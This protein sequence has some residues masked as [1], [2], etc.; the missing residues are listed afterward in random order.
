MKKCKFFFLIFLFFLITGC[1][2][3]YKIEIYKDKVMEETYAWYKNDE[4]GDY[5]PYGK[6]LEITRKYDANGDFLTHDSKKDVKKVGYTGVKLTR[7]Y[8]TID[9]FKTDSRILGSCYIATNLSNHTEYITLKTTQEFTC[10]DMVEEFENIEIAVK[11]NHKV[12]EHNADKK[13]GNTYYWY[14]NRD[15][16]KNKP[17][18]IKMSKDDYVWNYDNEVF[19]RLGL[20]ILVIGGTL[21]LVYICYNVYNKKQQDINKI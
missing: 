7:R 4:L 8:P 17:I 13:K 2:G 10:Y 18:S 12:K 15:N 20:I 19:K 21:M 3:T 1:D 9:K 6:T 14:I 11:T 5:L 16:Y